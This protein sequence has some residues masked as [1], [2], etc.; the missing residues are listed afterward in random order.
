MLRHGDAGRLSF[1][2]MWRGFDSKGE[3]VEQGGCVQTKFLGQLMRGI[4]HDCGNHV[5]VVQS[6]LDLFDRNDLSLGQRL[7]LDRAVLGADRMSRMLERLTLFALLEEVELRPLNLAGELLA[8]SDTLR[9]LAGEDVRLEVSVGAA[10]LSIVTDKIVFRKVLAELVRNC[11][12]ALS[13]QA[14][15]CGEVRIRAA[16]ASADGEVELVVEDNGPGVSGEVEA[17]ACEPF[18]TTKAGA[19]GLG[20]AFVE[21]FAAATNARLHVSSSEG[22]GASVR[23]TFMSD[24]RRAWIER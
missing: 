24:E 5:A 16:Q 2:D 10:E 15:G 7:S 6:S 13:G 17:R 1:P 20:L 9:A 12:E 4:V 11:R 19:A 3:A 22:M 21:C 14:E 23:L 8:L 18:F